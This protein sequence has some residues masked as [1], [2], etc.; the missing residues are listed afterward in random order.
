V[1]DHPNK[2]GDPELFKAITEAFKTLIDNEQRQQ[3]DQRLNEQGVTSLLKAPAEGPEEDKPL[4]LEWK[5]ELTNAN[6]LAAN[7]AAEK[8]DIPRSLTNAKNAYLSMQKK[9]QSNSNTIQRFYNQLRAYRNLVQVPSERNGINAK[10]AEL[11]KELAGQPKNASLESLSSS[12]SLE[13]PSSEPSSA[14]L[15][16][17]SSESSSMPSTASKS[18]KN[19]TL[20]MSVNPTPIKPST[21]AK[22]QL[23][24]AKLENAKKRFQTN[25]IRAN[26]R[27]AEKEAIERN[28]TRRLKEQQDKKW[29]EER[30]ARLANAERKRS[31]EKQKGRENEAISKRRKEAARAQESIRQ[32]QLNINAKQR[33]ANAKVQEENEI[34][35]KANENSLVRSRIENI[36][37]KT[38][39]EQEQQKRVQ[40]MMRDRP[41][42]RGGRS[43]TIKKK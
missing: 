32:A 4:S 40:Q 11:E 26:Q 15:D 41:L 13:L 2:G 12:D 30:L 21:A 25:K 19:R 10:I 5:P 37:R 33:E 24:K 29:E 22:L 39:E 20:K 18:R 17:P 3:Y 42:R 1:I 8:I 36:E 27:K 14:S 9:K 6:R 31:A 38:R 28:R 43:K 23:Q 35:R 34:Q 16:P 7:Q